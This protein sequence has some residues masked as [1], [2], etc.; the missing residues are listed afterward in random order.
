[1]KLSRMA[2]TWVFVVGLCGVVC[3]T[4]RAATDLTL[5][6]KA[7]LFEVDMDRYFV[8]EGQLA[9]KMKLPTP[10][11]AFI[12][13]NM[14]DNAYMTGMYLGMLSMQYAATKDPATKVKAGHAIEALNR[15]STVSGKK[16]LLVRAAMSVDAPFDDDGVWRTSD[17]GRYKW[18]GDVSSD[19]MDGVLYGYF[20]AYELVAN[21]V[22]KVVIARN[23]AAH[24]DHI[25]ENGRRIVGYDGKP[26]RWGSY[27]KEYVTTRE[28][29]NALLL[30][31][32]LKIAHHVTGEQRFAKAYRSIAVEDGYAELAVSARRGRYSVNYSDDVLNW[33]ALYPLLRL[34]QDPDLRRR[35]TTGLRNAWEGTD[36]APPIKP[37]QNPL[38]GFVVQAF[39]GDDS[40]VADGIRS[41]ELFPLDM[42]WN[43]LT[44]AKYER[45]FGFRF[46]PEPKSPKPAPGAVVP[47]DRRRK[48]WSVWVHSPYEEA[49]RSQEHGLEFS[50][51]DY[52]LAYW[53]GRY[54]GLIDAD[55]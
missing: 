45:E 24:V 12:A 15:L 18:R 37:H 30:L 9:P 23:V 52:L 42:K 10:E 25:L 53:L 48:Q 17:D 50:G 16:G 40:G 5:A 35:Y 55:R 6:E 51:H 47:I 8:D 34:E 22:E 31:Q 21:D 2:L 39:L 41:L 20:M 26:T 27:Y 4:A 19:Q 49:S 33:L 28:P 38:Y 3:G 11:R 36:D 29:M 32:H 44:I 7:Q 43:R 1:M 46:D 54:H 14:P 13:Y